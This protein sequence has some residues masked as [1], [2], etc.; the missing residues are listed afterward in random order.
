MKP[1]YSDEKTVIFHSTA[2]EALKNIPDNSVDSVVT[3]PPYALTELDTA[4]ITDALVHWVG[5]ERS[6]IPVKGKGFRGMEWDKF[7]PPPS[8]WDECFR[9]LK[10]GGYLLSFAGS[11]TQDIMGIS[12]RLGGFEIK[13]GIGWVTSQGFPKSRNI[14]KEIEKI[15]DA[16]EVTSE[17]DGYGT[18]MKPSF[19][20]IIVARKPASESNIAKNILK[21]GVGALNIDATR[22]G[23]ST[24]DEDGKPLGRWTPNFVL[25]HTDQCTKTGE[26]ADSFVRNRTE[27]WSGF[28]QR[29]R[30]DYTSQSISFS[31]SVYECVDGCPVRIL[32]ESTGLSPSKNGAGVTSRYFPAFMYHKKASKAE[33]PVDEDG[34][35]H[36]SVKPLELMQWL[37]RLVTPTGGV[38]ADP[39]IGSGTT[40]EAARIEGIR[41]IGVEGYKP[42]LGLI[43]QR[44][45]RS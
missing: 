15:A 12:I 42:Y 9:I 14:K 45:D 6:Y 25:A 17:W 11:R 40:I 22:V 23:T 28:G 10:P 44:L 20:P 7:V 33:K 31:T 35:T 5:G 26:V 16:S 38:V 43:S 8:L 39:F 41:S 19:E 37:V 13:D 32:A 4:K 1:F 24:K 30:P 34:E 21:H 29:E 27:E 36:V 2:L 3:D 18:A